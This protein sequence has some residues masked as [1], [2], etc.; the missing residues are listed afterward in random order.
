MTQDYI[1]Y[2][3]SKVGHDNI[4]LTFAGGILANAEGKVLL[5]LRADKKTW[6]IPGGAMELG[7]SSVAA[8]QREFYEETGIT[9]EPLRLL[10]VYTNFEETYPNGDKVQTVVML[11]EVIAKTDKAITDYQNDETL[12]L[13]YFSREEIAELSSISDKHRLMLAEYFADEFQMGH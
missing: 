1:S 8:C 2:I 4:I 3:R 9:V 13:G 11:Y 5:Q 12:R 10:N 7:E 6:A